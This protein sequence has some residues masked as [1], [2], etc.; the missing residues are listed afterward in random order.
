MAVAIPE[1][2]SAG[3]TTGTLTLPIMTSAVNSAP[4]SGTL[5]T[6][7]RGSAHHSPAPA[8]R[9]SPASTAVARTPSTGVTR[10]SVVS[11]GL[12]SARPARAVPGASAN[13]ATAVT[14]VHAIPGMLCPGR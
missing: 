10:P 13:M 14:A 4:P 3:S 12:P 5:Y 8:F 7:A 9:A 2:A 1:H 11:T 6:A